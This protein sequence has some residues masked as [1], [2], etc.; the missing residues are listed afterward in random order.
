MG[1]RDHVSDSPSLNSTGEGSVEWLGEWGGEGMICRFPL[2]SAATL[3]SLVLATIVAGHA[4]D[5]QGP[6]WVGPFGDPGQ[7]AKLDGPFDLSGYWVAVVTE[8]WRYRM[9]TPD[10]GDYPGR[11]SLTPAGAAIA[12]SVGSSQRRS[13]RRSVQVVRCWVRLCA[14]P[15]GY[16]SPGI[17]ITL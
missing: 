13:E 12:N 14:C 8:D 16:T 6:D 3:F 5:R 9:L 17:T 1:R 4:S 10:K 7:D 2:K 11:A 15:P